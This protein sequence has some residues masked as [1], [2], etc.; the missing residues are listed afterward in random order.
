MRL[1]ARRDG[2]HQELVAQLR[3]IGLSVLDLASCGHGTPDI[4]VG[5]RNQANILF[6]IKDPR[7]PP[8]KRRLT[9][10]EERFFNSWRGP[11]AVV[12]SLEECIAAMVEWGIWPRD[13]RPVDV[14]NSKY[15][16]DDSRQCTSSRQGSP[17]KS[18]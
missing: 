16:Q 9:P 3:A 11:R 4:L 17:Q 18:C 8:C 14:V 15:E 6:E 1:R 7:Q 13:S 12:T 10:D 5:V 2:N